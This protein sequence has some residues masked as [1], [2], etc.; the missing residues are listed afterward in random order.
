[1]SIEARLGRYVSDEL[2]DGRHEVDSGQ[3]LLAEGLVDSLG[4]MRL[5]AFIG[6]TFGVDVPAEDVVIDN[7]ATIERMARYL[8]GRGVG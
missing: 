4:M 8:R 1:M 2:L 6:D 3:R 7:F 5:V